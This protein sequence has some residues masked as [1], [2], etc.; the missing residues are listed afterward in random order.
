[1][2]VQFLLVVC[3]A[4]F[5]CGEVV[6]EVSTKKFSARE[7]PVKLRQ[8]RQQ[9]PAVE[10]GNLRKVEKMEADTNG[11][12]V[13]A[14]EHKGNCQAPAVSHTFYS[15]D[16][17]VMTTATEFEYMTCSTTTGKVVEHSCT[18]GSPPT[19]TETEVG[20]AGTCVEVDG[21][22]VSFD[23]ISDPT[24]LKQYTGMQAKFYFL[25]AGDA[26]SGD[27]SKMQYMTVD[28]DLDRVVPLPKDE[29]M[30]CNT[31]LTADG[32]CADTRNI[33]SIAYFAKDWQE[34]YLNLYRGRRGTGR[35]NVIQYTEG[36]YFVDFG[37]VY[38]WR[39]LVKG[40]YEDHFVTSST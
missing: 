32:V 36:N 4:V 33:K 17:V 8:M 25:N 28:Y 6:E 30:E 12:F 27:F 37:Q 26:N 31:E 29:R 7:L 15:P 23:C 5:V 9:K 34:A 38:T 21:T 16:N 22:G 35:A 39:Y 24:I 1:M 13:K 11:V 18:N 20:D 2:L 40:W 3:L 14:T 10:K 19:C